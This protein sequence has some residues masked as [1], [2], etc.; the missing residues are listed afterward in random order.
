MPGR[1]ACYP[2]QWAG[3][4]LLPEEALV[5]I[6]AHAAAVYPDE[7]CGALLGRTTAQP[8]EILRAVPVGN[9]WVGARGEHY[10]IPAEVVRTLEAEA[11]REGLEVVGFYHSHPDGGAV[12]SAFDL[13]VAWPWYS[14][15][16]IAVE[17]GEIVELRG[18]QLRDERTGFAEQ[19]IEVTCGASGE[20][21][22]K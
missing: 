3:R 11:G 7:C 6:R 5:A 4:I 18:W 22:C 20:G 12:P 15:L 17:A 9:A 8:R 16:I 14:Y 2:A 19:K 21:R 1:T 13:E 10:L